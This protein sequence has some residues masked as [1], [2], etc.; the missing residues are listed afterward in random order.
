MQ[1]E[2]RLRQYVR[3]CQEADISIKTFIAIDRARKATIKS[4]ELT[5]EYDRL[6]KQ[7]SEWNR[8]RMARQNK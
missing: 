5:Q 2:S 4:T 3:N 6:Q 7:L 8:Q 1:S